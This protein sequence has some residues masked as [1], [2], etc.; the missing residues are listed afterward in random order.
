MGSGRK[1]G[2]KSL[3]TWVRLNMEHCYTNDAAMSSDLDL[4]LCNLYAFL[5]SGVVISA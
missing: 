3:S 4:K 5:S 2:R 1:V